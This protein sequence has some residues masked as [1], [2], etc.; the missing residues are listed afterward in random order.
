MRWLLGWKMLG[1]LS[2]SAALLVSSPTSAETARLDNTREL[3]CLT[4]HPAISEGETARLRVVVEEHDSYTTAQPISFQW[5]VSDGTVQGNDWEVE[6][7]LTKVRIDPEQSHKKVTATVQAMMAGRMV[8]SCS[9]E[10]FIGKKGEGD[11]PPDIRGG[12]MTG[13]DYL[14]PNETETSHYGLYSYFLLSGAPENAGEAERY[15]KILTSYLQVTRQLKNL[16]RYVR[17]SQLNATHIPVTE[18]PKGKEDD[19]GFAKQVLASYDFDRAKVLLNKFEKTYDRGPYLIS[20][21]APLSQTPEP[22]QMHILQ[23]F[24]RTTPELAATTVKDFE[25]LAAQQRTWTEQSMRVLPTKLRREVA[26]AA[27]VT[28]EVAGILKEMIQFIK[29]GE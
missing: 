3:I 16:S 25:Y 14:L 23:D 21:K 12:L 8:S 9:V 26:V 28:P 19:P 29:L 4:D 17:P 20:V 11:V 1:S 18:L 22:V 5:R 7:N 6:W 2:I 13:R 10:V 27:K 15:L 24:S